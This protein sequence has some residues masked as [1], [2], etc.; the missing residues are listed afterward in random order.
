[1][2]R[3]MLF[4]IAVL[5]S[6]VQASVPE[7]KGIWEFNPPDAGAATIGA[8]LELKGTVKPAVGINAADGAI[9]I[10]EGSYYICTH[11]LAPNGG[12]A[13]VNEWTLLIDFSYPPSSRSDPPSG[14]NDLFQTN[15]TNADD[16]DWTINSSG[17]V[18]IGAVGYSSTK[19]FTTNGNIWYRMVVVVD[20][21]TRHDIYFDGVEIFKGNQQGVD[22][23]FSLASTILLFCAGNNQDRDDAPINVSTVAFWDKPLTAEEIAAIGRAGDS[24]FVRKGASNPTP[25][26]GSEDVLIAADLAWTPGAYA[27]THNVYFGPSRDDVGAANPA[28]LIAEGLALDVTTLDVGLLDY[29]QTYFWRVDGV[30]DTPDGAVYEGQVWS[31]TT[32]T[33]GYPITGVTATASSSQFGM[34]PQNTVNGSGLNSLDEHSTEALQMWTSTDAKPHWIR[35]E[36]DAV[37]RL[38]EMWVWNSN[39]VIESFVGFGAKDVAIEYSTDG[40][41]WQTLDGVSEFARASGLPTYTA[42]TTVAFDGVQAKYVRL[43]INSNWGIAPQAGLSE[44]RFFYVPVKAFEPQPADDATGVSVETSLGWR[45]GRDA[46]SHKVYLGTDSGAVAD[47]AVPAETVTDPAF[48]PADLK[49]ATTY[50]WKVDEVGASETY[51]GDLWSFTTQDFAPIDDMEGY[52]DDEGSRIYEAWIDGITTQASGSTVGYMKAPFAERAIVHGGSQSMPLAYNNAASPYYSEA[53]LAFDT[54]QNWIAHGA[55]SVSLYFQG[56]TPAFKETGSGHTLMNGIGAD[57]WGTADQF[58]FA[59]KTLTGNGA[60]VAR[61]NSVYNSNVWA[62]AGVMIRQ[63][64]NAGSVH[65]FTCITPGGAGGGNGGSFQRRPVVDAASVNDNSATLVAAPYWVRLERTGDSFSS[66][67]SPD[68]VAWTQLGTP[69]SIPMTGPVLIGLALCSHSATALTGAD[70]SD[71]TTTGNV[72]GAWQ[73]AEIG[74]TQQEGNSPEALYLTVKDSAGRTKTIV[75]PD[76][77]ASARMGWQ[78]WLIPLSDLTSGG[79]KA[80]AVDSI[81]IGV[82]NRTSPSAG[83]TG[84]IYVDDI[85]FGVPLP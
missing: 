79:L 75:N 32:E 4:L 46:A 25:A 78:Q 72:A 58:R 33:Y 67:I 76:A 56:V 83:G 77:T 24:F 34:D 37:Y 12:G 38:H 54:P 10:G 22:G 6:H 27:A 42:N 14:Y 57:I 61:V 17:A 20:N 63:S 29:G 35:F 21:G 81:V 50:S 62:K 5:V 28:A 68:G 80:T 1:M 36:F 7:P 31:F 45:A 48:A 52:T 85:G 30:N 23:R 84:T 15:P 18:G 82:G 70:F 65:A 13:K 44:V 49:F 8:P 3:L 69:V 60:I 55:N 64:T 71:V 53:E 16:A 74:V 40:Q 39:Q 9:L 51:A 47:G 41:T 26:N 19:G 59:H 43:S 73:I 2:K 11:G 66:F